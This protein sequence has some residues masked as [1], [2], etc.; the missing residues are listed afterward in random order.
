MV[1]SHTCDRKV[2]DIFPRAISDIHMNVDWLPVVV[3]LQWED[4][5]R[6]LFYSQP[7]STPCGYDWRLSCQARGGSECRL[8][9][10][11]VQLDFHMQ[12]LLRHDKLTGGLP[13]R[14][15]CRPLRGVLDLPDG[16]THWA[17]VRYGGDSMSVIFLT[18]STVLYKTKLHSLL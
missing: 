3:R 2:F 9:H 7:I 16:Q 1:C 15:R 6:D 4:S 14:G 10:P 11:F 13:N 18:S 8:T 17:P 5:S 12:R